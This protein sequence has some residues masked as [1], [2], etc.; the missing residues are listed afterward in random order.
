MAALWIAQIGKPRTDRAFDTKHPEWAALAARYLR[1]RSEKDLA[2]LPLKEGR[3]PRLWAVKQLE[4]G[5]YAAIAGFT[6]A[7]QR[8]QKVFALACHQRREPDGRVVDAPI[9]EGSSPR[10]TVDAWVAEAQHIGG[11]MWILEAAEVALRWSELGD[12]DDELLEEYAADPF[13]LFGLP[14]G[15]DPPF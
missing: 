6:N 1:T 15:V 5:A 2:K 3:R 14:R 7:A 11:H 9:V 4:P 13:A 8:A 10:L 12:L